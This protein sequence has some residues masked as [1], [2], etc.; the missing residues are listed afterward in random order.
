[1]EKTIKTF[2]R[3]LK[4]YK[5]NINEE[6]EKSLRLKVSKILNNFLYKKGGLK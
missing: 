6:E 5:I 1:M 3:K 4:E 2:R